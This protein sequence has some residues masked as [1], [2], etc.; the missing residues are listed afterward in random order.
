MEE[1]WLER[2]C[3][4][5]FREERATEMK[6][7]REGLYIGNLLDAT[8]VKASS[9]TSIT[10]I[11]NLIPPQKKAPTGRKVAPCPV[12]AQGESLADGTLPPALSCAP[13]IVSL[14]VPMRDI[15]TQNLLDNI[16]VCLDFIEMGLASGAVLVHC[17][18]GVSRRSVR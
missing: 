3:L 17:L 10:H 7:V 15:E 18:A 12:G 6:K 5:H 1:R 4:T 8:A 9:S 16:E 2:R 11:L 13:K 14:N